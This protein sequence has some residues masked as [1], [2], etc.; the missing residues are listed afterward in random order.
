ML[1]LLVLTGV[2]L[3]SVV[4]SPAPRTGRDAVRGQRVFRTASAQL[5]REIDVV[6]G[7][8]HLVARPHADAWTVDGRPV[9]TG[10][11]GA[12][13]ELLDHLVALRALDVF[14]PRDAASYGFDRPRATI[15]L[16]TTRRIRRLLLG[17]LNAAGSALY[18]RREGDPRVLQ[19]GVL[20]LSQLEHVFYRLETGARP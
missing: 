9:D 13:A 11:A 17:D 19:V 5:V 20:L 6:L 2:A 4:R 10:T 14:R 1:A 12:L 7:D 16:H 3:L 15:T 18:A 8:R